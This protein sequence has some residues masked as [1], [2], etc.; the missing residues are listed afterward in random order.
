MKKIL[1]I[2]ALLILASCK[3]K[4]ISSEEKIYDYADVRDNFIKWE[5]IL[6]I[7]KEHYYAYVFSFSCGHCKEIKQD[8][9]TKVIEYGWNIYFIEYE[10][11]IP[12]VDSSVPYVGVSNYQEL[13][14]IGTPTLFE[15][16]NKI[17]VDR[18]TGSKEIIT[19]LYSVSQ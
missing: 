7:D 5:E 13:G 12:I 6:S 16:S 1:F 11:E 9:L 18:F 4:T 17:V 2:A 10:S 8:I 3:K 19:T 15:I 14:I